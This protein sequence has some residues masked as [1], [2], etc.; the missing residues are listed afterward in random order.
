MALLTSKQF[1]CHC[2]CKCYLELLFWKSCNRVLLSNLYLTLR[3][4][5]FYQPLYALVFQSLQKSVIVL[6]IQYRKFAIWFSFV[7][8]IYHYYEKKKNVLQHIWLMWIILIYKCYSQ[9][10]LFSFLIFY[11]IFL[12]F[13]DLRL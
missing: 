11:E 5:F 6:W 13:Y 2:C 1:H 12:I 3:A 4:N 9:C 10:L 7:T 8:N